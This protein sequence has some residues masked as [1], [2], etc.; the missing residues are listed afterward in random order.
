MFRNIYKNIY[1]N[2]SLGFSCLSLCVI[3]LSFLLVFF[4]VSPVFA[5]TSHAAAAE[6]RFQ[7]L[8]KEIRRLTGIIEG[9]GY[10]IRRLRGELNRALSD[11]EV[12]V[13]EIEKKNIGGLDNNDTKN[14][15]LD[16]SYN[17]VETT[18]LSE[19]ELPENNLLNG[20]KKGGEGNILGT[21]SKSKDTGEILSFDDA[22]KAYDYAYSFIKKREFE[23][24][25]EEFKKF[26]E[27]FPDHSLVANAKYWYGETFYVRGGYEKAARIFAEGYK[28][29]P[30]GPKAA[31]NLLKLGMSLKGM[32]KIEDA[33]IAFKQLKKDYAKSSMPVLKRAETE[34]N[35]IGCK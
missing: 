6:I 27:R 35:R 28:E 3:I 12:R 15:D 20:E 18:L 26:I 32:G 25:E 4:A 29:F 33:C 30:K 24:A 2:I 1:K 17:N 16:I 13:L 23:R 7:Q 11:L 31:S 5:Q 9:Q 14:T 34:M 21:I 10:E 22:P 8:E 19:N